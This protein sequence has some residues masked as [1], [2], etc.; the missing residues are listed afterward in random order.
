MT[1]NAKGY[2][3]LGKAA[4]KKMDEPRAVLLLFD[5]INNRIGLKPTGL[6][7]KNAFPVTKSGRHGGR[8]VRAF[9]LLVEFGLDIKETLQFHDALINEDGILI[10]DLR[11]ARVSARAGMG[12]RIAGQSARIKTKNE[13]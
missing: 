9:R 13:V 1:I 4:Y 10:L 6:G 3:V 2:I 7:I 8:M 11:S 5:D 12:R